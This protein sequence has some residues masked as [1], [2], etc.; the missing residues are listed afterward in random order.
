MSEEVEGYLVRIVRAT[1]EHP[2]LS[3]GASPRSSVALYRAAQALA[4]LAGRDFVLPDDVVELAAPVL[5][6]RLAVDV[7]R[8]L[9]GVTAADVMAEVLERVSVGIGSPAG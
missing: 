5:T 8:E 4:F 7:D 2:D 1:R 9:R 3:L 6:H